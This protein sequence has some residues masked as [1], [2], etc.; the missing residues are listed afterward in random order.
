[1]IL[2]GV[3]CFV[4]GTSARAAQDE[5]SKK[6]SDEKTELADLLDDARQYAIRTTTP[7]ALLKLH[8]PPVFNFTN[9]ERNQERGSV[10]VWLHDGRP[11]VIGQFFRFNKQDQRSKK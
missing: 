9:A 8:E 3:S 1:T 4:A 7:E 11:T 2:I 5:Q 10:F 6:Q